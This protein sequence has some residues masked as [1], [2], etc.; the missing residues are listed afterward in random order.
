MESIM[1]NISAVS[2][3]NHS[4]HSIYQIDHAVISNNDPEVFPLTAEISSITNTTEKNIGYRTSLS[5]NEE[6]AVAIQTGWLK[7]LC[8]GVTVLAGTGA[9]AAGCYYGF[10]AGRPS[11]SDRAEQATPPQAAEISVIAV[12]SPQGTH[13]RISSMQINAL[14]TLTPEA[15]V[16]PY[17]YYEGIY[18]NAVTRDKIL[19]TI[20]VMITD[21]SDVVTEA[22][23]STDRTTIASAI[24]YIHENERHIYYDT[25]PKDI[26]YPLGRKL[27][28]ELATFCNSDIQTIVLESYDADPST[29][30][31]L[32]GRIADKI[33]EYK[34][35]DTTLREAYSF[36]ETLTADEHAEEIMA[37]RKL[38]TLYLAAECIIDRKDAGEFYQNAMADYKNYTLAELI[39]RED[40]IMNYFPVHDAM[41]EC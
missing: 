15:S 4:L 18:G 37:R 12:D 34:F 31:K 16:S 19:K 8:I 14:D 10:I 17:S 32:L 20:P 6:G 24:N 23:F 29:K 3:Q 13:E 38:T 30:C 2:S 33:D 21:R 35:E 25:V 7:R 40:K 9:L 41:G 28:N 39:Q 27:H 36:R 22:R 5:Q 26:Y 1:H 11:S